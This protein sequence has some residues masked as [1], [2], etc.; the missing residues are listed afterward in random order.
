MR[1]NSPPQ[2]FRP[3]KLKKSLRLLPEQ[4]RVPPM[5]LSQPAQPHQLWW[6]QSNPSRTQVRYW[7]YSDDELRFMY[8][9]GQGHLTFFCI[10]FCLTRGTLQ[11]KWFMY[12]NRLGPSNGI[13]YPNFVP[14]FVYHQLIGKK[15]KKSWNHSVERIVK[16]WRWLQRNIV[17]K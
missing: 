4:V 10:V 7:A 2:P 3:L 1:P 11:K 16:T 9:N 14:C 6:P 5:L 12:Q 8:E 17:L 15:N 13:Y